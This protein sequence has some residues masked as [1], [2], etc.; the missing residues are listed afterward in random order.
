[1]KAVENHRLWVKYYCL[2]EKINVSLLQAPV[3]FTLNLN[4][5]LIFN[6]LQLKLSLTRKRVRLYHWSNKTAPPLFL[7]FSEFEKLL[8]KVRRKQL[9]WF[10]VIAGLV[11]NPKNCQPAEN[12]TMQRINVTVYSFSEAVLT[13]A[14]RGLA[15]DTKVYVG[16][17]ILL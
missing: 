17:P 3:P 8:L 12:L 4:P 13:S 5:R 11:W 14:G 10:L 7:Q 2:C 1:M 6:G 15:A 16:W 9:W